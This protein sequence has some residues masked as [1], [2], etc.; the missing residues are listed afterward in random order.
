MTVTLSYTLGFIRCKTNNKILLLNRNKSPWMGRWNGVGGKLNPQESALQCII[1]ETEEET[2]LN[3]SNFI[4]RGI[5][6][7]KVKNDGNKN[8]ETGGLYLFTVDIS[9]E[10]FENY[11]TPMVYNNEGILD[12]KDWNWITNDDN[13]GVVDNIKIIFNHLFTSSETDLYKV[14]YENN[15]LMS[16]MYYPGENPLQKEEKEKEEKEHVQKSKNIIH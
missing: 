7:W 1:R 6:I 13:L 8:V 9:E 2:G 12:W 14:K 10:Q 16:C 3:L 11:R 15:K 5:L 4:N